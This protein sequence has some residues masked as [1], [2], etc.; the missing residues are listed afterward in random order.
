MIKP[1]T[2]LFTDL[3]LSDDT[4]DKCYSVVDQI[5][6]KAVELSI[7]TVLFGGDAFNTRKSQS[8]ISLIAFKVILD[9]FHKAG[10][11]LVAIDGNHDK[12]MYNSTNSYLD[13]YVHHPS[14]ELVKVYKHGVIKGSG[15]HISMLS[16]FSDNNQC[17]SNKIY[18]DLLREM[19]DGILDGT[20]NI[21]ITHHGFDQSKSNGGKPVESD[22]SQKL[23]SKYDLVLVGHYH[24]RHKLGSRIYYIGSTYQSWFLENQDKG[25]AI[26]MSDG[27]IEYC[28]TSFDKYTELS[29]IL[30]GDYVDKVSDTIKKLK[31][32]HK[33]DY[34]RIHITGDKASIKSI[35]IHS[36]K[37]SGIEVRVTDISTPVGQEADE[38]KYISF[39][40]DNIAGLFMEFCD[41][42]G[43]VEED[44]EYG[45]EILSRVINTNN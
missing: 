2:I 10:I 9:K 32:K 40:K 39:D 19:D 34:K 28:Q 17:T 12:L 5:V 38:F 30:V 44:M 20:F 29:V 37:A 6:D 11:R 22:L 27:S 21:L 24:D 35:D 25:C 36:I 33:N 18:A 23:V 4:V 42:E 45:V 15:V 31:T 43:I 7:K 16:F 8:M 41:E 3:H 26:I 13:P 1:L 14:L